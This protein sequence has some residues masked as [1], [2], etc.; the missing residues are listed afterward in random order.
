[1]KIQEK[2]LKA[3]RRER[4]TSAGELTLSISH[5][6]TMESLRSNFISQILNFLIRKMKVLE[7]I[8]L[9]VPPE[10]TI[11]FFEIK[12]N[13]SQCMSKAKYLQH[14]SQNFRPK[15]DLIVRLPLPSVQFSSVTLLSLTLQPHRL[16]HARPPCPSPTPRVYSNW[17]PLSQ[18][19]HP[20]ISSS[21]VP[22]SSHLQSV[23]ASGSF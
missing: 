8:I 9:K 14:Y 17:C 22:F 16:Q 20:T 18:W 5:S 10:L 21:V 1:M 7:L 12:I 15:R 6:L 4:T 11:L 3:Q 19:C 2:N 23:P 13:I